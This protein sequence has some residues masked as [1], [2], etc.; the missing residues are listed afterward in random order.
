MCVRERESLCVY[1]RDS[2]CVRVCILA[3]HLAREKKFFQSLMGAWIWWRP[4]PFAHSV[5]SAAV[6]V[7]MDQVPDHKSGSV[8]E[9]CKLRFNRG[10]FPPVFVPFLI[11]LRGAGCAWCASCVA[12]LY[13]GTGLHLPYSPVFKSHPSIRRTLNFALVFWYQVVLK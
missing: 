13:P 12:P 11:K 7:S 8:I 6:R 5:N 2:L 10:R 3:Q 9:A 4:P 1:A